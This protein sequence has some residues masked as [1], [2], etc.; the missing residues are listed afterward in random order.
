MSNSHENLLCS[1]NAAAPH[2]MCITVLTGAS[3]TCLHKLTNELAFAHADFA[4]VHRLHL[5]VL[6]V[7]LLLLLLH[8][9]LPPAAAAL[10]QLPHTLPSLMLFAITWS[11]GASCDKA[12]R[13]VFDA[14]MRE[15]V[16]S[17]AA[18]SN[19]AAEGAATALQLSEGA[20]MP[21]SASVYEW[22]YDRQVR[23]AGI[24]WMAGR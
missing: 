10:E 8:P 12:G 16:A 7:L 1:S 24:F 2:H 21:S 19:S 11:L 3:V 22:C 4:V 20:L 14:F 15:K 9:G 17:L 18:A 5:L 23:A 13:T 6:A